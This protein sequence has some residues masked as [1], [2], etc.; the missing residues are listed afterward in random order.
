MTNYDEFYKEPGTTDRRKKW[1]GILELLSK[2]KMLWCS[3]Y[4]IESEKCIYHIAGFEKQPTKQE[5]LNCLEELKNDDAFKLAPD[6]LN[7]I[8]TDIVETK[9]LYNS[10]KNYFV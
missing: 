7:N 8:S 6:I 3:V 5:L 1:V 2:N 9:N 10:F 4:Y